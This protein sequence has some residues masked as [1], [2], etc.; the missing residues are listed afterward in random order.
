MYAAAHFLYSYS[1]LNLF[2]VWR[3]TNLRIICEAF[4]AIL[5]HILHSSE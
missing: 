2:V 1:V 3:D 5:R 4:S